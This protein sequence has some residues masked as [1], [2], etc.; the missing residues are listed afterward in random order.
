MRFSGNPAQ[1]IGAEHEKIDGFL[2]PGMT[3][4]AWAPSARMA[5]QECVRAARKPMKFAAT[6][7]GIAEEIDDPLDGLRLDFGADG[8]EYP[9]AD[10]GVDGGGDEV[11]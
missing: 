5:R 7:R 10:T 8:S 6:V 4:A 3:F 1:G 11:T 2:Y 9:A